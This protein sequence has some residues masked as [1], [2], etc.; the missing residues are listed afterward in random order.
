MLHLFHRTGHKKET[1]TLK[2]KV[3]DVTVRQDKNLFVVPLHSKTVKRVSSS[4]KAS[5]FYTSAELE[6]SGV[7]STSRN[8]ILVTTK[9]V[10]FSQKKR[11]RARSKP[12]VMRLSQTGTVIWDIKTKGADPF[13]KPGK[14]TVSKVG[15]ICVID[16][17]K[18][19]EHVVIL[20]PDGELKGKY[21]GVKDPIL[22]RP[23]DPKDVC[24]DNNGLIYVADLANSAVHVLDK[25]GNFHHFLITQRDGIMYPSAL[26]CDS[27]GFVWVGSSTGVVYV[28]DV[29]SDGLVP[30]SYRKPSN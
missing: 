2:I 14:L 13:I 3:Q 16:A 20:A 4:G 22:N 1:R 24:F 26:T 29:N 23:F 17:E 10:Q 8:E 25:N 5:D 7:C 27:D 6:T 18:S 21:Y 30:I 12:S 19:R 9:S 11:P 28:F 15:D